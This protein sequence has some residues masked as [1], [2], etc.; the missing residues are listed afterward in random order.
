MY[1]IH[2]I[3]ELRHSFET[4]A[5]TITRHGPLDAGSN[6]GQAV[7]VAAVVAVLPV[8]IV[9][10]VSFPVVAAVVATLGITGLAT[11]TVATGDEVA[12]SDERESKPAETTDRKP[13]AAT[14]STDY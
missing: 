14:T 6:L 3:A 5:K 2:T 8:A 10:A 11:L 7:G 12:P 4:R 1:H 13:V 9:V